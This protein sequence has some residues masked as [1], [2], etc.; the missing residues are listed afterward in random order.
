MGTRRPWL[1]TGLNGTLAPKLAVVLRAR[2]EEVV[3]W[4][5]DAVPVDDAEAGAA[6]LASVRPAGIFHLGMG[7]EDCAAR[8]ARSADELE[9]PFGYTSSVSV[10]GVA[11]GDPDGP[12]HP[13]DRP[14]ATDDYGAYKA[15]CEAAVR[16]ANARAVVARIGWQADLDGVGNN[17]VAQL[18]AQ[19]AA[20]AGRVRASRQWRPA[21]S[22]MPDTAEALVALTRS[23][24]HGVV[25]L[26][27]NSTDGWSFADVVRHVALRTG[28]AWVVDENDEFVRDSRLV[29]GEGLIRPLSSL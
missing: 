27:S 3:G 7:A 4:D 17:M 1:I 14:T 2:G 20:G 12:F 29:G 24:H 26:D 10:F 15:R 18:A 13:A 28:Q 5:R 16:R 25:H 9:V 23:G 8:L 6:F 11:P 22:W 19:A 21:M